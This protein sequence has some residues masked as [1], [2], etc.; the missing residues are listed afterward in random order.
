MSAVFSIAI[1]G[2]MSPISSHSASY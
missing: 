2:T 1:L